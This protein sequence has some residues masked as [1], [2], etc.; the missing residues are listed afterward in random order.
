M[1]LCF[2]TLI[3]EQHLSSQELNPK[4]EIQAEL[5]DEYIITVHQKIEFVNTSTSVWKSVY[6][7]GWINGY[8]TRQT[9][10]SK[11]LLEGRKS[12]LYFAKAH[13]RGFFKLTNINSKN[14]LIDYTETLKDSIEILQIHLKENAYPNDTVSLELRYQVKIPSGKF[15]GYGF[16]ED[17]ALL[18]YWYF[19]P[20]VF[21]DN[22]WILQ[23]NRGID[24]LY[25]EPTD[26]KI[27]FSVPKGYILESNLDKTL[28]LENKYELYGKKRKPLVI[29]L[30]K[31]RVYEKVEESGIEFVFDIHP[32][33]S[34]PIKAIRM[35][36]KKICKFLTSS[37]D[38]IP[39]S[40]IFLTDF[41][42]KTQDFYGIQD[43]DLNVLN[44]HI[45]LFPDE[46][47]WEL[48]LLKQITHQI[49]DQT[50]FLNR[51]KDHWVY[52]GIKSYLIIK[53]LE[54][55]HMEKTTDRKCE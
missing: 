49:L 16:K 9:T 28:V 42:Q 41:L 21:Q 34:L 25:V 7:H 12:A 39:V 43:I 23:T 8:S 55:F 1:P 32:K 30:S 44:R 50:L 54:S 33:D 46:F 19:L 4:I 40:K 6:L 24:D 35:H 5:H 48:N 53:Y 36:L 26:Y 51:R 22:Q 20:A 2:F 14:H 38:S 11:T 45:V 3:N 52:Q 31:K 27:S 18:K 15:T 10:L 29:G 37:L 13:Q 17:K 47:K